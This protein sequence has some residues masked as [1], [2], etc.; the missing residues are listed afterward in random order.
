[1]DTETLKTFVKLSELRNFTHTADHLF[2]VQST[3]TNRIAEL[4]RQVGKQLFIRDK[5]NLT[6]TQEGILFLNYAKRMIELEETALLEINKANQFTSTLRIGT[7]NTIYECHLHQEIRSLMKASKDVAT[8]VII[9]HS[10]NLLQML[11]DGIID[12]V[13]TYLPFYKAKFH[14]NLYAKDELLLVTSSHN[15]SYQNGIKKEELVRINYLFCNFALQ[16]VGNFIRELFP[17][18]Y[19][20][21]FEIDNSTKLIPYLLDGI[22]YSFLPTSLVSSYLLNGSLI[23]IPLLDFEPPIIQCY[24]THKV[25]K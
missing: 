23:S 25:E 20:F 15:V 7:T 18:Y 16:E 2:V 9:D 11:Q 4:E 17:P 24:R 3:I 6:L 5:K 1:M 10:D 19:Q 21:S 14:C 12:V 13:Y 8:K 22:G